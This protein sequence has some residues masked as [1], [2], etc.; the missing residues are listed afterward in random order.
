[1]Q[2][3]VFIKNRLTGKQYRLVSRICSSW[4]DVGSI[5]GIN[6]EKLDSI[7]EENMLRTE[8][9]IRRVFS[10]WLENAAQLPKC[11]YYPLSWQ[12][13]YDI[14]LDCEFSTAAMEYFEFLNSL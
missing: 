7:R 5:L 9:R 13:L 1:M 6:Q 2:D 4:Q 8:N 10:L 14:L 11:E 12:G 3:L